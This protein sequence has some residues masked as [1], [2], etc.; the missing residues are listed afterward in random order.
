MTQ[1]HVSFKII[2][3]KEK[4][5]KRKKRILCTIVFAVVYFLPF[6]PRMA[7]SSRWIRDN[8]H[9]GKTKLM[10]AEISLSL[11]GSFTRRSIRDGNK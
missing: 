1:S 5:K 3:K 10:T 2:I 6:P 7:N 4:K 11:N 8:I 9:Q